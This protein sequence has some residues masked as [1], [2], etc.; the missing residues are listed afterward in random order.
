MLKY[1]LGLFLSLML[2]KKKTWY[3]SVLL[4]FIIWYIFR[5][6]E[7]AP[8]NEIANLKANKLFCNLLWTILSCKSVK[9]K[10][11]G[12]F[13]L[14]IIKWWQS[15]YIYSVGRGGVAWKNPY[16]GKGTNNIE[17]NNNIFIIINCLFIY[18]RDVIKHFSK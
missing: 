9:K 1:A 5:E 2:V 12:N 3:K 14:E 15:M 4:F 16:F 11:V 17:G 6:F 7:K 10:S 8:I 13:F 18:E